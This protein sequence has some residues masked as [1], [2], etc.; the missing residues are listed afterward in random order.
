MSTV[1]STT[2]NIT[3]ARRKVMTRRRMLS[4]LALSAAPRSAVLPARS[5]PIATMMAWW[6][7]MSTTGN[8][9]RVRP[10]LLLRLRRPRW[11]RPRRGAVS[12]VDAIPSQHGFDGTLLIGEQ[13]RRL[14][15]T[16]TGHAPVHV[17]L[18]AATSLVLAAAPLSSAHAAA[19]A[20]AAQ[21]PASQTVDDFYRARG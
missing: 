1:T 13:V 21:S 4:W 18:K 11:L 6:T 15:D 19:P 2:P 14:R 16:C 20:Q 7:D 5:G 10:P 8:I 12:A 9:M 17:F 3:R